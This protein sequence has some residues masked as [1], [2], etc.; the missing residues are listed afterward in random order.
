[1]CRDWTLAAIRQTENTPTHRLHN[2]CYSQVPYKTL[3]E[4]LFLW[5]TAPVQ[6]RLVSFFQIHRCLRSPHEPPFLQLE[7]A[8]LWKGI[9]R[10][11]PIS[12]LY[13]ESECGSKVYSRN[14]APLLN[15]YMIV[16]AFI[17]AALSESSD[18]PSVCVPD[19]C[20][21][22]SSKSVLSFESSA[23]S[24]LQRSAL[25]SHLRSWWLCV[26]CLFFFCPLLPHL[27][28]APVIW[29]N[30]VTPAKHPCRATA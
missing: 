13:W 4:Y 23:I 8:R 16:H 9:T 5:A 6:P 22:W 29:S 1:M 26:Y 20:N 19:L 17:H 18:G 15:Y 2:L 30:P 27:S 25:Q 28:E 10:R 11:R 24:A 3:V 14:C 7:L 12:W 21:V